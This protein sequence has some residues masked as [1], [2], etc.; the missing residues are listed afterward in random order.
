M[1]KSS[2]FVALVVVSS[3]VVIS[4]C[5]S[6]DEDSSSA[7]PPA[8]PITPTSDYQELTKEPEPRIGVDS[9]SPAPTV[10]A[11]STDTVS[12]PPNQDIDTEDQIADGWA[13]YEHDA[14]GYMISVPQEWFT[15]RLENGNLLVTNYD[16]EMPRGTGNILPPNTFE[17]VIYPHVTK[18]V[19]GG[20]SI[21]VGSREFGGIWVGADPW[22]YL[23]WDHEVRI[24]YS[25]GTTSWMIDARF[26][27]PVSGE[28]QL[29]DTF[30]N[31]VATIDHQD[32]TVPASVGSPPPYYDQEWAYR[33]RIIQ[34]SS[35][36]SRSFQA[37]EWLML[38]SALD[39][40]QWTEELE[41]ILDH[42][43]DVYL[44]YQSL[45]PPTGYDNFH[46]QYF[47]AVE[48]N[49]AAAM[50]IRLWND[51]GHQWFEW[52]AGQVLLRTADDLLTTAFVAW[53]SILEQPSLSLESDPAFVTQRPQR[54]LK[55]PPL[56]GALALRIYEEFGASGSMI[57]IHALRTDISEA[58]SIGPSDY[59]LFTLEYLADYVALVSG[60]QH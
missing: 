41:S 25:A 44:G 13:R 12:H 42:W 55:G 24:Y 48:W 58:S 3:I 50:V 23:S 39:H 54:S 26:A 56:E 14:H 37:Y 2:A 10:T 49:A 35:R 31:V 27:E 57:T 15:Q 18:P 22:G 47:R 59:A 16:P 1:I 53:P 46:N 8:E 5:G 11:T 38:D 19:V 9:A 28:N 21:P 4:G 33:Q 60:G 52:T 34:D 32:R 20:N 7:L 40:V 43:H 36:L 45:T 6:T 29:V 17:F 30:A 51:T